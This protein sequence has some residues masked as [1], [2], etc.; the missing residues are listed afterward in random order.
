MADQNKIDSIIQ[1]VR[2]STEQEVSTRIIDS[3]TL[4][5]SV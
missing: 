3:P 5:F 4:P 2:D 1:T